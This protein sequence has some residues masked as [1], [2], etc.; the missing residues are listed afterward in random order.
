[1]STHEA[2][3]VSDLALSG[4]RV[5]EL[6]DGLAHYTG[7]LLADLGAEVIKI[8]PPAGGRVRTVPPTF[9]RAGAPDV[10]IASWFHNLGKRSVVLDLALPGDRSVMSTLVSTAD[11]LLTGLAPVELAALG[12]ERESLERWRPGLVHV[13]VTPFGLTGPW[14]DHKSSDL[15]AQSLGGITGQTGYDSIDGEPGVPIAPVGGV[16][17]QFAAVMAATAA[18][19]ALQEARV[20]GVRCLDIA[21]HDAIAVSTEIPVPKWEF[22]REEVL[23]HTGRHANTAA[24]DPE[25][26]VLCRDGN[27]VCAITVYLNDRR[28]AALRQW[29]DSEGYSHDL[30][31][32]RFSTDKLRKANMHE[33]TR[34]IAGFCA[35]HTAEEIFRGAQS[36]ALPW[37]RIRTVEEIARDPHLRERGFIGE[38]VGP[39]GR[40][41]EAPGAPWVGLGTIMDGTRS[42]RP[43]S[44]HRGA[45]TR[46]VVAELTRSP[47]AAQGAHHSSGSLDG[48][49]NNEGSD[50]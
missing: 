26:Q 12:I 23:R 30:D 32:E 44:P 27:Y 33:I 47:G 28:F 42:E 3:A 6:D 41:I 13:A 14:R 40:L 35:L 19:A 7:K 9:D 1:M 45:D 25:W 43:R 29:F 39:D 10:G 38:A 22:G 24:D 8:E 50:R 5:I 34:S 15:V 46:A 2:S 37:A 48:V 17:S 20:E 18:I 31:D 21:V 4:V 16:A 49:V 36:R 11:V